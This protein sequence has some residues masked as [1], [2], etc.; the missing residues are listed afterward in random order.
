MTTNKQSNDDPTKDQPETGS[1]SGLSYHQ[2]KAILQQSAESKPVVVQLG[3]KQRLQALNELDVLDKP[4]RR[5]FEVLVELANK[6]L[7]T[8]VALISL[9]TDDRQFFLSSSGLGEP[10]AS[11]RETPLS[12]SFCQHVVERNE[13]LVVTDA[14]NHQLVKDNLAIEDLGVQAYLGVPVILPDG[15]VIG[16][17]CAIDAKPRTWTQ[18]DLETIEKLVELT[19]IELTIKK[20]ARD[21]QE[22]L[23]IRLR[24]AQKMQAIGQLVG[25]VAHDFNNVLG[26]IQIQT[27]LLRKQLKDEQA[28]PP[29]H[30]LD[31]IHA[32]KKIVKQLLNWSRPSA[33]QKSPVS[34]T[35]IIT[36]SL[37][38]ISTYSTKFIEIVFEPEPCDDMILADPNMIGQILLNL[39][40]NSA[41]AMKNMGGQIT[42]EISNIE[43][44]ADDA[45]RLQLETGQHVSLRISDNGCGIPEE[46]IP[47]IHDPYFTTKP[48]G[49]GTG[50]GLWTV[51]GIV[52]EHHGQIEVESQ[53]DKGTSFEIIFPIS[54]ASPGRT[55]TKKP[56]T[57]TE[58]SGNIRLLVV[59]DEPIITSGLES[60]LN[61]SGYQAK[62]FTS[63]LEALKHFFEDPDAFDIVIT[64]Q[65]M[66]EIK[67]EELIREIKAVRPGIPIILCSGYSEVFHRESAV[68]LQ[69]DA[70]C[71][72]P[73]K[74]EELVELIEQLAGHKV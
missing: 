46:L 18:D 6:F 66:P 13:P 23:E 19:V 47:R 53:P 64:D 14:K 3:D 40:S 29:K 61:L 70:Y 41:Y 72:K 39:C 32:A 5:S 36:D 55:W 50:L 60:L 28:T 73:N 49:E 59:D 35:Q 4:S 37:P 56:D 69:A 45:N 26:A 52:K 7:G 65:A 68:K 22:Q 27:E 17:F 33:S 42:I 48:I 25:G 10:W 51:W 62:G 67:G 31:T 43:I 21:H 38:L 11:C 58:T 71:E 30:I 57:L 44:N 2:V 54:D 12:H 24:Q 16:S 74:F 20:A 63:G 9:V 8:P 15:D 34:L 1:S